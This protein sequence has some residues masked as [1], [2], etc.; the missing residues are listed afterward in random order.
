[1]R[2]PNGRGLE[3]IRNNTRGVYNLRRLMSVAGR[4]VTSVYV[5]ARGGVSADEYNTAS[6]QIPSSFLHEHVGLENNIIYIYTSR[7]DDDEDDNNVSYPSFAG[8]FRTNF[9]IILRE[10]ERIYC[11][12]VFVLLPFKHNIITYPR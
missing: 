12:P 9:A 10:F 2:G 7:D 11:I 8:C 3:R 4:S 5:C 1:M 6:L